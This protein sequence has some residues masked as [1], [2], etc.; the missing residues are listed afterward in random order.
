MQKNKIMK[1]IRQ[2]SW[3]VFVWCILVQILALINKVYFLVYLA[4]VIM[5]LGLM[6]KE[7]GKLILLRKQRFVR[8]DA[9]SNLLLHSISV[10]IFSVMIFAPSN[11]KRILLIV[12]V[13][14]I[15]TGLVF[16]ILIIQAQLD[17][18]ECE[19]RLLKSMIE[20]VTYLTG[21]I[22]DLKNK[23]KARKRKSGRK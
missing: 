19:S 15:L 23:L 22:N 8:I 12:W 3:T 14:N 9:I 21:L 16:K 18:L 2:V 5:F 17:G 1:G 4:I 6:L 13:S 10:M 11:V 7:F 20:T